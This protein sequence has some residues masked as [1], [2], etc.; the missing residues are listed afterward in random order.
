M[1]SVEILPAKAEFAAQFRECL[2]SV[3]KEKRFL[4]FVEAP[5]VSVLENDLKAFADSKA[6]NFFAFDGTKLIGWCDMRLT[7]R[8]STKHRAEI[9]MGLLKEYRGKGIGRA[10]IEKLIKSASEHSLEKLELV[11]IA[12]NEAAIELYKSV[13]FKEEGRILNYRKLNGIYTD[14]INMG[15]FLR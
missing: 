12:D 4:M 13:G 9:G 1:R 15:L 7:S 5:P 14:A 3:A 8:E 10:L 2:D 11:V 6:S